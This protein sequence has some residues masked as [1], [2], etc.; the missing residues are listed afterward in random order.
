MPDRLGLNTLAKVL[1]AAFDAIAVVDYNRRILYANPSA[2]EISGYELDELI[3]LDYLTLIPPEEHEASLQNLAGL[4]GGGSERD[5]FTIV[6]RSGERREIDYSA[7]PFA[8]DG[9][10]FFVMIARDLTEE[11]RQ[12]RR[13]GALTSA[14]TSMVQT[15]TLPEV[16]DALADNVVEATST[17][18]CAVYLLDDGGRL[19][20]AGTSGLPVGYAEAMER[21]ARHG[22]SRPAME[23]VETRR[24]LI[25]PRG[26]E[27]LMN[28]PAFAPAHDLLRDVAWEAVANLPMVHHGRVVGVL[29]GYYPA[30]HTPTEADVQFLQSIA[31]QAA[32]AVENARLF[33]QL[34]DQATLQERQR[35]ARELHDSVSQAVYG[36]A[37]G[38]ETAL[39]FLGR[40]PDRARE[41]LTYVIGLAQSALSEMRSLIFELR[42]ESLEQEGLVAALKKQA[43]A[44]ES[45]HGLRVVT[46]LN[47]E[48]EVPFRSKEAAYRIAQEALINVIKHAGARTVSLT[49][50]HTSQSLKLEVTDD[51][52]GFNAGT[53]CPGH[54]GQRTM[55]ERATLVGG[56]LHVLSAPG[57]GTTVTAEFPV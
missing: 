51:G 19:V 21:S 2:C 13:L 9:Q 38:S 53:T 12:S 52:V 1:D 14:T 42:P 40:D 8:V 55:S 33:R 20:A 29:C 56:R 7:T 30:D 49:L 18:G 54:L 47:G 35:L 27:R 15:R 36:M 32:V 10:P 43:A 17:V 46:G 25:L 6:T 50:I 24:P 34:H 16:L 4:T 37:L 41:A 23:A 22:A 28:D 31:G 44:L 5:T 11:R 39:N 48:P 45:R 3:G 57:R 26:R